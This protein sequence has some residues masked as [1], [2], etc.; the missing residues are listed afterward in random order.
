MA[1]RPEKQA[2]LRDLTAVTIDA[3]EKQT[4]LDRLREQISDARDQLLGKRENIADRLR[5][6]QKDCQEQN[7][8][9]EECRRNQADF[10]QVTE[11]KELIREINREFKKQGIDA[12]ARMACEYVAELKDEAWRDAI[13]AFLNVHRYAIIVPPEYFDIANGVMD[14]SRHRYVELVNTK[15]LRSRELKCAE[16]AV[17]HYL[18]IQ[19]DAAAAVLYVLAGRHSCSGTFRGAK[20]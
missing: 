10:S 19:N 15:R 8:I 14:A 18:D 20:I 13:E 1:G 6:V 5:K 7:Q 4:C 11:Q 2:V 9:I 16:D 12:Q 17:Y 3:A